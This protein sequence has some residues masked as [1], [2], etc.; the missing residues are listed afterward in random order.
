MRLSTVNLNRLLALTTLSGFTVG[1][2]AQSYDPVIESFRLDASDQL[3]VD[4]GGPVDR[5]GDV[6]GDNLEDLLIGAGVGGVRVV[7]GPTRGNNGVLNG[8]QLDGNSGFVILNDAENDSVVAGLGDINGDGLDDVGVASLTGTRVIYGSS[9]GFNR[10]LDVASLDGS[11]GFVFGSAAT[12]LKR[13]GDVNADGLADFVVGNANASPAGL[14]G[15]GVSY[16]IFG[17]RDGFPATF[18][19]AEL[20]GSN[21]FAVVGISAQDRTGLY[22]SGAGDFNNDGFDDVLV[23]APYQTSNGK[24]EAGAAYLLLGG[25]QFPAAISLAD[26]EAGRGLVFQ[27]SEI[28]ELAGAAVAAVGDL[29]HDGIDDLAIGAPG[30]G[31]FGVPSD[32]PGEVYVLFGGQFVGVSS[33][34]KSELDGTNGF[35]LRGIRGGVIPIEEGEAIWG[36][37]AGA[38][39]DTAGDINSD[40]IVDIMIGAPH[41]IINPSRKGVG[42]VYFVFGS[43]S[44][45]PA[46]LSLNDLDG[47]NGFRINGTGTVDYFAVSVASAGDFND[48][49]RDD[50]MM[51]ASG[52]GETY[53]FYGRESELVR[54]PAAPDAEQGMLSVGFPASALNLGEE[55]VP[56]SFDEL[57]DPTG[58]QPLPPGTPT[59]PLNP[60]T[61]GFTAPY[62]LNM[63]PP[64]RPAGSVGESTVNPDSNVEGHGEGDEPTAVGQS[65]QGTDDNSDV[66]ADGVVTTG[67]GGAVLWLVSLLFS[68]WRL[69]IR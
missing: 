22:V 60:E 50:V 51:G 57:A 66:P 39:I 34:T 46:T 69:R 16:V 54:A 9:S 36:D 27:G 38:D 59:D 53:V 35:V 37:M 64:S 68:V 1:G 56:L 45:F 65:G 15:A 49:G 31:P 41:T 4:R 7:F 55:A 62:P 13:A 47:N 29:N 28:Q 18:S 24:S 11:N 43:T 21:G 33:I 44:A 48:D 58:P 26:I 17:R 25:D 40:G 14:V 61:P 63:S 6:N 3:I 30:K 32:Y 8:Q 19:P 10:S 67:N 42:Q 20:T 52:Q 5:A 12:D 2:L 23:G